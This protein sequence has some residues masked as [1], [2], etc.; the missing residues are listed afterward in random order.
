MLDS[1]SDGLNGIRMN[2]NA[3]PKGTDLDGVIFRTW[4][5]QWVDFSNANLQGGALYHADFKRTNFAGATLT[6]K[7]VSNVTLDGTNPSGVEDF[8]ESKWRYSKWWKAKCISKELLQYLEQNDATTGPENKREA[9]AISCQ[10]L[11]PI[12][13]GSGAVASWICQSAASAPLAP[14]RPHGIR[15]QRRSLVSAGSSRGISP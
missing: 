2:K 7:L 9:N 3:V 15:Q 10:V 6:T 11:F 1:I 13:F 5:V 14:F 8:A 4:P 12:L